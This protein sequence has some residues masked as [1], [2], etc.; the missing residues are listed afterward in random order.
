M[1]NKNWKGLKLILVGVAI[2]FIGGIIYESSHPF[3]YFVGILGFLIALY[4]FVIHSIQWFKTMS[5]NPDV[6][7][8]RSDHPWE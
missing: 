7:D 5:A 2:G 8:K 4:G 3:G 6:E 1:E